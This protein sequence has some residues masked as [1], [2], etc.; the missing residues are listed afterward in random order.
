MAGAAEKAV[1]KSGGGI[2]SGGGGGSGSE[3]ERSLETSVSTSGVSEEAWVWLRGYSGWSSTQ[4]EAAVEILGNVAQAFGGRAV[5]CE[6]KEKGGEEP[7]GGR[8]REAPEWSVCL[9]GASLRR[10]RYLPL[11]FEALLQKTGE[12]G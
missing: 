2:G 6:E 10:W 7:G 4:K 5:F 9:A 8:G 11:S 12:T 1:M 3:N